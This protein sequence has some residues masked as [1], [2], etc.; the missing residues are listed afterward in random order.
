MS[1]GES[2]VALGELV[3]ITMA[4]PLKETLFNALAAEE[5]VVLEG[6]GVERV[7]AAGVQLLLAFAR[8]AEGGPGW[9]WGPGGAADAL[10]TAATRLGVAGELG[11]A[12]AAISE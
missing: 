8:A 11:L 12:A 6:N 9:Q 4:A 10:I 3:D 5:P 2:A 1:A 7:D